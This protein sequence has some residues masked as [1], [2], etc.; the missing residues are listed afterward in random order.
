MESSHHPVRLQQQL[1]PS[2][3][4]PVAEV[5][6]SSARQRQLKQRRGGAGV[7]EGWG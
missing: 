7:L 1:D 2:S 4:P 5:S 6:S 3:D